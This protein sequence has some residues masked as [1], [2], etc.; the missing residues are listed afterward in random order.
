MCAWRWLKTAR[1]TVHSRV[2]ASLCCVIVFVCLRVCVLYIYVFLFSCFLVFL[3]SWG[4]CPQMA[5]EMCHRD[6]TIT[7]LKRQMA[8]EVGIRDEA[9]SALT[10]QLQASKES[11]LR[12]AAVRSRET[13]ATLAVCEALS[14]RYTKTHIKPTYSILYA[15][16]NPPF[17]Y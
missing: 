3:F 13:K 12:M 9:I 15:L 17:L 8:H 14:S 7:Q 16:L 1:L 10:Q 11:H 2:A 4:N 5:Q 6:E